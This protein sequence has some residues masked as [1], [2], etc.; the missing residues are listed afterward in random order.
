M[1]KQTIINILIGIGTLLNAIGVIYILY[2]YL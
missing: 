2:K 1:K